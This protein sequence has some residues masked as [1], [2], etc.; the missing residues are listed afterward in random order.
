MKIHYRDWNL[1]PATLELVERA[2]SI[3]DEFSAQGYTLT[4]R[5]LY[6][7]FVGRGLIE[8]TE[9][10]YKNLGNTITKAR[11][12]GMISWEAIED[13]GR[14]LNT[15]WY[16]EDD[17]ALIDVLSDN[18][19]FDRWKGQDHYIEVWVEKEALGNV[20]ERA[21]EPFLVPHLSCKGFLSASEAW[22][23]GM[24]LDAQ[25]DEG[26]TCTIIHLGDHDPSGIDMTRDNQDRLDEFTRQRGIEVKRIALNMDQVEEHNPPPN[27][28]KTTDSRYASYVV[29]YGSESRELDALRPDVIVDLITETI[30]SFIDLDLW[31]D[32]D[33]EEAA[34]KRDLDTLAAKWP[35]I[36]T[37]FYE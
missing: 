6:Y 12:A 19:R 32:L 36:K 18:I 16:R 26:K 5:Q 21:C 11:Y 8:N 24:R 27:P 1:K 4:L 15:F 14:E 35:D 17:Q 9:R 3:I 37:S 33:D 29:E 30:E 31:H 34:M 2:E 22:R 10:S 20:I 23:A 28:A 7:Q 25:L 13:R